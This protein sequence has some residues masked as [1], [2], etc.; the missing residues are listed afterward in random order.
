[1]PPKFKLSSFFLSHNKRFIHQNSSSNFSSMALTRTQK[2]Q[3][4]SLI[5]K[6][7]SN[8]KLKN[9][10]ED[11]TIKVSK[12]LDVVVKS[13]KKN[14]KIKKKVAKLTFEETLQKI[15][16]PEDLS[17]PKEYVEYHTPEFII[18]INLIIKKDPSL[19]PAIVHKP[20]SNFKRGETETEIEGD[21][22]LQY[23]YALI[24]SV[25]SQ[26]I[27]GSAARSIEGKF[28]NLFMDKPTPQDT[29]K[30]TTEELRGAG[31]SN[32]KVKYVL[33][34]SEVFSD[35]N[36][37]LTNPEFYMNSPLE[38]IVEE[39]TTL[40]G[41]GV[42][43]AKMFAIFTLRKMDVFAHDDLGIA[44]G[45][46]RYLSKRIEVLNEAKDII[47]RDDELKKLLK[48]KSKFENSKSSKRDWVP[49]HDEYVKFIA[50]KFAPYQSVFMMILWR[51]SSTNLEVLENVGIND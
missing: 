10:L 36:S 37:K 13:S 45:M 15:E 29:L 24:S 11:H 20:F 38:L 14:S 5:E 26:Q 35:S 21:I 1:M 12:D 42:W 16:I 39:L 6:G 41:I 51:L 2:R 40:K 32:M 50:S 28:K 3:S 8:K 47:N 31:L 25:I 17:L 49:I 48:K 4:E 19:Y 9:Q 18:G 23:W 46:A 30:K 34:I 7:I 27:S 43:S 33:H 44:R 22:I